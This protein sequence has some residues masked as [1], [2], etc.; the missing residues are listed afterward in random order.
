[1]LTPN[2]YPETPLGGEIERGDEGFG[3]VFKE[4]DEPDT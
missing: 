4:G 3:R 1:M 2:D